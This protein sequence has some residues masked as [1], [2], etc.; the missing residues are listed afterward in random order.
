M[1]TQKS[2]GFSNVKFI[3]N[4]QINNLEIKHIKQI[5]VIL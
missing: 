4:I 3:L 1:I 2:S 5:L